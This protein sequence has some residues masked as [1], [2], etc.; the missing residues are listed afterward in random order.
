MWNVKGGQVAL[1]V[2][3]VQ[4]KNTQIPGMFQERRLPATEIDLSLTDPYHS[5]GRHSSSA[6][7]DPQP[8]VLS[9]WQKKPTS[10]PI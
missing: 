10:H 2:S 4:S 7:P 9:P 1:L 8:Q 5:E 6:S 3:Y